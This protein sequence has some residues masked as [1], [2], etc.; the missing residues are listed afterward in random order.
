MKEKM[1]VKVAQ[2]L[3]RFSMQKGEGTVHLWVYLFHF[4]FF[5]MC[6]DAFMEV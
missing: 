3:T 5:L 1:Q 6:G 2:L 4:Y